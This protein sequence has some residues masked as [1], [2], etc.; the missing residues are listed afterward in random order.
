MK[1][2]YLIDEIKSEA[3]DRI[4]RKVS[5]DDFEILDRIG[6]ELT[7]VSGLEQWDWA[8]EWLDPVISTI[9][10]VTEYPLPENFPENFVRGSGERGAHYLCK[11]SNG[12]TESFMTYLPIHSFYA[13]DLTAASNGT[14][15][16]YTV[17][18]TASNSREIVVY[19]PPD[20]NSDSNYTI[21][22]AYCPT[23]WTLK[24][25][26][27]LPPVPG[28]CAILRHLTLGWYFKQ[29]NPVL[30]RDYE[31]KAQLDLASLR[32]REAQ[33]RRARISPKMG[34]WDYYSDYSQVR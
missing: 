30:S 15:S 20:S 9:T 24:E 32:L 8:T 12:S 17:R 1:V 13:N 14:P 23:E 18:T 11:L 34:E 29:R 10:G 25:M 26:D 27:S 3:E 31:N 5:L 33:Q 4:T 28:N 22:G 16:D 2:K 6:V 19:P 21:L 7:F